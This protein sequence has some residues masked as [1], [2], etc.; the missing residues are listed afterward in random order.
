M[1]REYLA[2]TVSVFFLFLTIFLG[3]HFLINGFLGTDPY[4]HFK[5]SALIAETGNLTLVEPWAPFHFLAEMPVDPWWLYHI[6]SA[7]FIKLFGLMAG[8]KII[9]AIF[10]ALV[11]AVFYFILKKLKIYN[12]FVWTLLFFFASS[13]FTVRLLLE[14]PFVLSISFLLIGY[15]FIYKKKYYHLFFISALY[16]L[17]Y[18]MAPLLLLL[19]FIFLAVDYYLKKEFNLKPAIFSSAG[20]LAGILLHPHALNY[21]HVMYV[22]FVKIF[23]LRFAGV[24][25]NTGAEIQAQGFRNFL[26]GNIV[27]LIFYIFATAFFLK[28][29]LNKKVERLELSLFLI[30]FFWFFVA[31]LIP[32]GSEYWVPFGFLFIAVLFYKT[33]MDQEW[34]I[35]KA[36]LKKRINTGYL[37]IF[38]YSFIV[39]F[40]S[41]NM[42]MVFGSIID[43]NENNNI[44]YYFEDAN[45]WLIKNTPESSVIYYPVWSMF[46]RMFFYNNHNKYLTAFD[47]TFLYDY[48]P[49]TY[50]TWANIAYHGA[51]CPQSWPC[52]DVSPRNEIMAI[53][54]ALKISL[55]SEYILLENKDTQLRKTLE[56][57]DRDFKKVYE[58]EELA[59]FSVQ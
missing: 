13:T 12:P 10:G 28:L 51:Y 39:I 30:S 7:G 57:L 32:R 2:K 8:A 41:Y 47:P 4:Y 9:S 48:N 14:R 50:Y 21:L 36:W 46:P 52:M 45:E 33:L 19:V 23:Y 16:M 11:F 27:M 43:R 20:L 26:E 40:S 15:Y 38:I 18:N 17:S 53:K 49:K 34:G 5:H 3:W 54:Y 59:I 24:N 6:L 25:L 55:N 35:A 31:V 56:F 37:A 22:H 1:F 29:F 58:N 44:D 42:F